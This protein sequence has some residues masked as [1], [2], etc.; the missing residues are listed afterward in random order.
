MTHKCNRSRSLSYTPL[1]P[2]SKGQL[3]QMVDICFLDSLSVGAHRR[4]SQGLIIVITG[5]K[6]LVSVSSPAQILLCDP[7]TP[8]TLLLRSTP[9]FSAKSFSS[10]ITLSLPLLSLSSS[11]SSPAIPTLVCTHTHTPADT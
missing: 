11:I 8:P 9:R 7:V 5:V 6:R 2:R 1:F 4:E 10:L 3:F